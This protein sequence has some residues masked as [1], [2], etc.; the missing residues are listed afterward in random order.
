[1]GLTVIVASTRTAGA[2][3]VG[4]TGGAAFGPGTAGTLAR[5]YPGTGPRPRRRPRRL[6]WLLS[7]R[8]RWLLCLHRLG[9]LMFADTQWQWDEGQ[10]CTAPNHTH[11]HTR[12]NLSVS[13]EV[14][15]APPAVDAGR[16]GPLGICTS[17]PNN[18]QS[19]SPAHCPIE[20][21]PTCSHVSDLTSALDCPRLARCH[22][23][24]LAAWLHSVGHS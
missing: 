23:L 2:V 1:M 16:T 17:P 11:K 24:L 21:R 19:S 18:V 7:R 3:G 12:T 13:P 20:V 10:V 15:A 14:V 4:G 22:P 8:C 5:C 9:N 6:H